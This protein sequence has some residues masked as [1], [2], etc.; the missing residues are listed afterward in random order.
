MLESS[1]TFTVTGGLSGGGRLAAAGPPAVGGA[2]TPRAA[3]GATAPGA[4]AGGGGGP[5]WPGPGPGGGKAPAGPGG[6]GA[7]PAAW[8]AGTPARRPARTARVTDG[9]APPR[10]DRIPESAQA[11]HPYAAAA[12]PQSRATVSGC[13]SRSSTGSMPRVSVHPDVPEYP[14][15]T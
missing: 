6:G 2:A 1:P 14:R 8:R 11:P 13:Q 5:R 4:A 15:R 3:G 7:G 9:T 12:W 10:G